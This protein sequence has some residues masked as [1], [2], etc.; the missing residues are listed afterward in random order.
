MPRPNKPWFREDRNSWYVTIRGER[1]NLGP[2]RDKAFTEFYRLMAGGGGPPTWTEARVKPESRPDQSKPSTPRKPFTAVIVEY[3][4]DLKTRGTPD[5]HRV[6]KSQLGIFAAVFKRKD[7]ADITQADVRG[8]VEGHRAWNSTTR[9]NAYIRLT[10]VFNWAIARKLCST[11]P[12]HGIPKPPALPRGASVL[13]PPGAAE[14]LIEAARPHLRDVLIAL[15][16]TGCR[17]SEVI[18]VTAAMFDPAA[19]IWTLPVHKTVRKT[20]EA[21]RIHLIE[22]LTARCRDLAQT[23]P[24]GP[25]FRN[26]IGSPYLTSFAIGR[27]VVKLR[28]KLGLPETVIAYSFRHL[29]ATDLL[30]GGISD[31]TVA[32]VLGH[33]NTRMVNRNYGHANAKARE[34][35]A[36]V[37]AVRGG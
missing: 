23:Y 26:Y 36:A 20:G 6:A 19:R 35:R 1:V 13:P 27:A 15:Y 4:A 37:D 2:D 25:L 21:R 22:R 32:A 7:V 30:V 17:P 9:H 8:A 14:K 10:A 34:L 16:D 18:K 29:L 28:R 5:T 3:L 24:T 12:V 11:N 33:T 31:A